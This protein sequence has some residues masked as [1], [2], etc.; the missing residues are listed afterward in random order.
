MSALV[1]SLSGAPLTNPVVSS[2]T[3]HLYE[4]STILH[5]LSVYGSCPH[6]G[7]Q[8]DRRDLVDLAHTNTT[9]LPSQQNVPSMI[10][11]LSS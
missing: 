6:T 11:K 3:G 1:C 7:V 8:L 2:K 9:V 10:E 5:Y 4:K